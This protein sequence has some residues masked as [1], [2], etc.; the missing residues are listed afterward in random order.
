MREIREQHVL[1]VGEEL[2]LYQH[3][4]FLSEESV[5]RC[6]Q[7][8]LIGLKRPDEPLKELELWPPENLEWRRTSRWDP[9][10]V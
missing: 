7:A 5:R 8:C 4:V 10:T 6:G 3:T 2:G 9:S 1:T